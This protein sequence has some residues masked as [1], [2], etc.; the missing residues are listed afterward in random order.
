MVNREREDHKHFGKKM[1]NKQTKTKK[2]K[3]KAK[4]KTKTKQN[5]II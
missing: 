3:T 2:K 1:T 4:T 5:Q